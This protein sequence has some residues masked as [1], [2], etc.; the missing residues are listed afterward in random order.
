MINIGTAIQLAMRN[1]KALSNSTKAGCYYC[2]EI[3]DP[4]D[5]KEYTDQGETAICPKCNIDAV[6]AE[7]NISKDELK[8]IHDYWFN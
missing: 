6:I 4:K 5:I 7:N 2:L 1:K 3:Y 8:K